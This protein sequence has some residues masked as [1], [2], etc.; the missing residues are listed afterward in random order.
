MGLKLPK[1]GLEVATAVRPGRPSHA[2]ECHERR[3]RATTTEGLS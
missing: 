1:L 3:E 2:T